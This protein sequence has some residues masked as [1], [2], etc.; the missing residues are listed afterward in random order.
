MAISYLLWINL[1]HVHSWKRVCRI[2]SSTPKCFTSSIGLAR[3]WP[4][5]SLTSMIIAT[6]YIYQSWQ[7]LIQTSNSFTHYSLNNLSKYFPT[8]YNHIDITK[9]DLLSLVQITHYIKKYYHAISWTIVCSFI[10]A[11]SIAHTPITWFCGYTLMCHLTHV[12]SL[13]HALLA[14]TTIILNYNATWY[15]LDVGKYFFYI[16]RHMCN[17]RWAKNC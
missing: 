15:V 14:H 5:Y 10:K 9:V 8:S 3:F 12:L 7:P 2:T 1:V 6:N 17:C 13:W 16:T 11:M 4:H